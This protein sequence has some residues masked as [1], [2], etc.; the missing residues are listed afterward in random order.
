[1]LKIEYPAPE[2]TLSRA[3]V[4]ALLRLESKYF[5]I[6]GI[7]EDD[8]DFMKIVFES[9]KSDHYPSFYVFQGCEAVGVV[10]AFPASELIQRRLYTSVS[11]MKKF[12]AES[13]IRDKFKAHKST[14]PPVSS[15]SFYLSKIL[16][17]PEFRSTGAGKVAL[18][19]LKEM[20]TKRGFSVISLH[21][22]RLNLDAI[23]FYERN[24]F[25]I[26]NQEEDYL[27]MEA[28]I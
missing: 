27:A 9:E 16:I 15:S 19:Q 26:V 4:A 22:N 24:G 17:L 2:R 10:A 7:S 12:G 13:I 3:F 23:R 8:Y 18:A 21:V 5:D 28:V 20:A 25:N 1:M 6:F 11:L 14:L